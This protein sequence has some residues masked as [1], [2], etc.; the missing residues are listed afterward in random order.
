M[1]NLSIFHFYHLVYPP[2]CDEDWDLGANV[3]CKKPVVCMVAENST[4]GLVFELNTASIS[5][6]D[7]SERALCALTYWAISPTGASQTLREGSVT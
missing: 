4:F 2:T 7:H 6:V 1:A 3:N 5:I